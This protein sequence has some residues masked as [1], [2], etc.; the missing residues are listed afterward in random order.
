MKRKVGEDG[1]VNFNR[2]SG[3]KMGTD[4]KRECGEDE[5]ESKGRVEGGWE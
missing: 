4:R 1:G 2:E 3:G 5:N